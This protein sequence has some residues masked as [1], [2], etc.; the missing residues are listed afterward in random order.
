VV[1]GRSVVSDP[2]RATKQ[3]IR[4]QKEPGQRTGE[5]GKEPQV[6]ISDARRVGSSTI[7]AHRAADA[8]TAAGLFFA[9]PDASLVSAVNP[10]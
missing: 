3:T 10:E 6:F 2:D 7:Q 4:F 1:S 8:T 9:T 5:C